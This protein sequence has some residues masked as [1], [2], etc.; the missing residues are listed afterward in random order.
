MKVAK[1]LVWI[2]Q[3]GMSV[4]MPPAIFIMLA[5]WL[6]DSCGWG[7]WVLWVGISLGVITAI[8]GLRTSLKAMRILSKD[9]KPPEDPPVSFNEHD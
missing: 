2:T 8:D 4:A 5:L 7:G 6:R 3:L 9:K 1:L